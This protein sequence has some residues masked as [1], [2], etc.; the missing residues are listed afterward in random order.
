MNSN[1][2]NTKVDEVPPA[3]LKVQKRTSANQNH[4]YSLDEEYFEN[5]EI[6]EAEDEL[7]YQTK[8]AT[9]QSQGNIRTRLGA[10]K[11]EFPSSQGSKEAID[12]EGEEEDD[13]EDDDSNNVGSYRL[14]SAATTKAPQT[15]PVA[16]ETGNEESNQA[17][18]KRNYSDG[19][20]CLDD[21]P[22]G[23]SP[24]D[25]QTLKQYNKELI[26]SHE[27]KIIQFNSRS[28]A[29]P[30]K[31]NEGSLLKLF[32]CQYF[33]IHMLMK[34]L[35]IKEQPGVV[36]YLI[37]KLFDTS[38]ENL[39][40]YLPQLCYLALTKESPECGQMLEKFILEISMENPNI[41]F[42]ALHFF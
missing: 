20:I 32:Q 11:E 31:N 22:K 18:L 34:Y 30:Q 21:I 15:Q 23:L 6:M 26:S 37:N 36:I 3:E 42:R 8:T 1:E 9:S 17:A 12:E 14:E 39:D 19:A 41:G 16:F 27:S 38:T 40:L 33:N 13:E 7:E 5:A 4:Q 24:E 35:E 2:E 28:T 10:Q 25:A 29:A